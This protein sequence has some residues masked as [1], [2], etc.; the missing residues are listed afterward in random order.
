MAMRRLLVGTALLMTVVVVA[1]LRPRPAVASDNLQYI[2]PA[3]VGGAVAVVL[4]IAI[5]ISEH[6]AEPELDL[7]DRLSPPVQSPHR[8]HWAPTCPPT[9]DTVPL[10]CW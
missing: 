7:I 4:I 10:L 8:L 5:I 3:A 9:A 1:A 6:K 2:I